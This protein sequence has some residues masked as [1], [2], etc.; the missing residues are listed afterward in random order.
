MELLTTLAVAATLSVPGRASANVSLAADGRTVAAAWSASVPDGPTD[1]YA[2]VSRDGGITF[3]PAVRVNAVDGDAKINGEQPPKIVL[4]PRVNAAPA[5]VVVWPS[6]GKQ[7]TTLL[8]ARSEDGGKTFG[9]SSLVPGTDAAGL[10]GW[11][12]VAASPDGLVHAL[13]LDH[14]G[15]ASSPGAQAGS[16]AG[17]TAAADSDGVAMSMKSALY[18]SV[19]DRNGSAQAITS[20]VCFCCKTA[21][22]A[23]HN[24][25]LYAVWRQVFPGGLRDIAAS[26]SRDGG[27]T[28]A[29]AAKVSDD[30]WKL[31]ACPDDG[32]ALA[33]DRDSRVHVVWPTLVS[34]AGKAPAMTLFYAVSKD[35]RT[36]AGRQRLPSASTPHHPQ[37]AVTSGGEVV[38]AWD[39]TG[40]GGRKVAFAQGTADAA[41]VLTLAKSSLTGAGSY[42]VVVAT[43]DGPLAA[44][45]TG[46]AG[47]V[48]HVERLAA[49]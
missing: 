30:R 46:G 32:P 48:I 47:S 4:V 41:G 10:R 22:A 25:E 14:R 33:V 42:P 13:W 19:A 34:E 15:M 17:H 26:V 31:N 24:G 6:T 5:I 38:V 8:M 7:G 16:H 37:I 18:T 11:Q 36:F 23:G 29:P 35:G 44:W 45:T 20:G 12:S 27:R 28:F 1:V 43:S 9:R 2:S 21:I 39:E 40:A 3:G 49:R